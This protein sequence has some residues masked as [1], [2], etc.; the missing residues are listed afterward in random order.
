MW[1]AITARTRAPSVRYPPI[2]LSGVGASGVG[3]RARRRGEEV[4]VDRSAALGEA[5]AVEKALLIERLGDLLDLAPLDQ[6]AAVAA[7]HGGLDLG[8]RVLAVEQRHD[9]EERPVQQHDGVGVPRGIAKGHAAPPLVL[10]GKGF[11]AAEAW[12][13]GHQRRKFRAEAT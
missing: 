8:N 5:G 6:L 3:R 9:L 10:D 12:R 13:R 7:H 11:D 4:A 2:G 1:G